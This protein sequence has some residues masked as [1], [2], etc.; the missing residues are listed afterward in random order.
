[1][2]IHIRSRPKRGDPSSKPSRR[3]GHGRPRQAL[4]TSVIS[5]LPAS[6]SPCSASLSVCLSAMPHDFH[7]LPLSVSLTP[8]A[9]MTFKSGVD[10]LVFD[11][12]PPNTPQVAPAAKDFSH[13]FTH[14]FL[15][16]QTS[17]PATRLPPLFSPWEDALVYARSLPLALRDASPGAEAWRKYIRNVRSS[18]I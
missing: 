12:T 10:H 13:I 16:A 8:M 11:V 3:T 9:R 17:L 14:A 4:N 7:I 15:Y 18:L 5:D 2:N 6:V 1:M